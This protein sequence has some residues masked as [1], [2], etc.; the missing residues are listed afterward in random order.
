[1]ET[2]TDK[3]T[4]ADVDGRREANPGPTSHLRY[5]LIRITNLTRTVR[6]TWDLTSSFYKGECTGCNCSIINAGAGSNKSC[7]TS[8]KVKKNAQGSKYS[9]P[10]HGTPGSPKGAQWAPKNYPRTTKVGPLSRRWGGDGA[11]VVLR[12]MEGRAAAQRLG[13][14]QIA[15]K[16]DLS[17]QVRRG[18]VVMED[19][20]L[21]TEN[22]NIKKLT[23][24]ENLVLAYENIK[25][26]PGNMTPGTDKETLDGISLTHFK[27]VQEKLKSG[28]YQF[29]PA[30]RI[31][32]PKPGSEE[33]RPL[34]IASPRDKIVQKALQQI[35]EPEYEKIF[36]ESSHGFRP[37]KGTHTAIRQVE[38]Q[39]Q[40]VRYIIEA[41][42]SKAFDNIPHRRLM[43]ILKRK[44][45][46]PKTLQL[47]KSA[48][49]A[50]YVEM[51][52]LHNQLDKSTPQG[53]I[54]SPLLCNIYLHEL[55]LKMEDL[56]KEYNRGKRNQRTKEYVSISNKIK[57]MS[58]KGQNVTKP[59]EFKAA[60]KSLRKIPSTKSD[61]TYCRI[62]YVRYADDFII[63]V[64][65]SLTMAK[66]I[67]EKV[68][69]FVEEELQLKLN[70]KKKRE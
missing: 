31:M 61:E 63:G 16:A 59:E 64:Q 55:D 23:N 30:R 43:N 54:L 20:Q 36:L 47:I 18:S 11:V 42:F 48:L 27:K 32:I 65:G 44:I 67:L 45:K 5:I 19:P 56:K 21:K 39:F 29:P 40:S 60:V 69:Q 70:D 25:S 13:L 3:P 62:Q 52:K 37:G 50:G 8:R 24:L 41:D 7:S 35:M 33:K 34:T 66:E 49:K 17:N 4:Q 26:K 1:V 68:R 9:K 38:S 53:S 6:Q 15:T 51:G 14:R 28:S 12:T 57:Y 22:I 10:G 2:R 58:K 46:C